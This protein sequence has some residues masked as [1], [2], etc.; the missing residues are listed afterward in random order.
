MPIAT[1]FCKKCGKELTQDAKFCLHCGEPVTPTEEPAEG[2][3]ETGKKKGKA[4]YWLLGA[5]SVLFAA[6]VLVAVF[7]A[8]IAA[9]AERLILSPETLMKKAVASAVQDMGIGAGVHKSSLDTPRRYGLELYLNEEIQ[10]LF[11]AEEEG[12]AWISDL[13]LQIA[14]GREDDLQRMQMSLLVKEESIVSLDIIQNTEKA[15]IGI[16]ELNRRYLEYE[17]EEL[18]L[19]QF[20]TITKDLLSEKEMTDLFRTYGTIMLD[21]IHRV[22][23]ENTTLEVDGVSQKVLKLTATILP[24]DNRK[25]FSQMAQELKEDKTAQ[26]LLGSLVG[27]NGHTELIES[28]EMLAAHA[29]WQWQMICYLDRYNKLTGLEL[30]DGAGRPMLYWAKAVDSG[31]LASLLTCADL[32]LSGKGTYTDGKKTGEYQLSV[33][34]K[35]VL[36]YQLKDF[37]AGENGFTGSI[38]FPIPRSL[39][40]ST[41]LG[42]FDV[43]MG[44]ELSQETVS[45]EERLALKLLVEDKAYV[46]LIFTEGKISDFSIDTPK[47]VTPAKGETVEKWLESFDWSVVGQ[48]LEDAGVPINALGNLT[49]E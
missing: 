9:W 40:D 18:E 25:A 2:K 23:K 39:T 33:D 31:N 13:N 28:L 32:V 36:T 45:G 41:A 12:G 4:K 35:T 43:E 37:A 1:M 17:K 29:D 46:G 24:E 6:G 44:L 30:L 11:S 34:G 15:W 8:D 14:T 21:S 22:S 48:R 10:E 3:A 16:P 20:D 47:A 42:L 38:L 26:R 49:E 7:F 5:A 27:E 19:D